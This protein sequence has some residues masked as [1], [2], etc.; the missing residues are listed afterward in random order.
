MELG[1]YQEERA[2][3][4]LSIPFGSHI[5]RPRAEML[6]PMRSGGGYSQ[7]FRF[8]YI[9]PDELQVLDREITEL[10][11]QSAMPATPATP[12]PDTRHPRSLLETF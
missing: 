1:M 9:Q 2:K 6:F 11:K 5:L 10:L 7:P 3:V 12:R 4:T 8:T